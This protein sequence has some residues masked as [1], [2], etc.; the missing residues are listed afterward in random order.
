MRIRFAEI[1]YSEMQI[2][3]IFFVFKT[4]RRVIS[5][6]FLSHFLSVW[7]LISELIWSGFLSSNNA[8]YK[9]Q[10][11]FTRFRLMWDY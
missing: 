3:N 4:C 6:D 1:P 8:F 5:K 2:L 9:I 10:I 11:H 7:F